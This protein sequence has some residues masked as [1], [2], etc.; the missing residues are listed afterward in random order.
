MLYHFSIKYGY[1][2]KL[3]FHVPV[4][5]KVTKKSRASIMTSCFFSL[6]YSSI[7]T[8]KNNNKASSYLSSLEKQVLF[9]HLQM[10]SSMFLLEYRNTRLPVLQWTRNLHCNARYRTPRSATSHKPWRRSQ[11]VVDQGMIYLVKRNNG[12]TLSHLSKASYLF[13][14]IS[15][16]FFCMPCT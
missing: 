1:L 3:Q 9:G 12:L 11:V 2:S 13:R 8:D 10:R 16:Q 5:E 4:R 6:T 14:A 7:H 15:V